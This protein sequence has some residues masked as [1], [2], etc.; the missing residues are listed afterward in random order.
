M[1]ANPNTQRFQFYFARAL[2]MS[3]ENWT[4]QKIEA[5]L[6]SAN[7]SDEEISLTKQLLHDECKLHN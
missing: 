6:K 2:Q 4:W 5:Y 7:L 1:S 3:N